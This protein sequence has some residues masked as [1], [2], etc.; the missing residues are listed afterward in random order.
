MR[1][2]RLT[3]SGSPVLSRGR[4]PD[5]KQ[6]S[7]A[8]STCVSRAPSSPGRVSRGHVMCACFRLVREEAS[9]D[10]PVALVPS[11][12]L[13]LVQGFL[14]LQRLSMEVERPCSIHLTTAVAKISARSC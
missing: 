12:V 8:G 5:Q 14:L 10:N 11:L 7:N 4:C 6:G 9:R 13:L 1:A 3:G 2:I